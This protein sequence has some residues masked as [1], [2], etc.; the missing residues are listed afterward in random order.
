[1]K[2]KYKVAESNSIFSELIFSNENAE[3]SLVGITSN[4]DSVRKTVQGLLRACEM[5]GNEIHFAID[6]EENTALKL[7]GN[8]YNAVDMMRQGG[9]I[10]PKLF[11]AL[12]VEDQFIKSYLED[13]KKVRAQS[14]DAMEEVSSVSSTKILT[15]GFLQSNTDD[16][17]QE[18]KAQETMDVFIEQLAILPASK[19]RRLLD[20]LRQRTEQL[21]EKSDKPLGKMVSQKS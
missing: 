15:L 11:N 5:G 3:F 7:I 17:M 12:T 4:I 20:N 1:M 14:E 13:T 2:Y 6:Y 19:R 9:L 8:I 21:V 16:D 10:S 18:A